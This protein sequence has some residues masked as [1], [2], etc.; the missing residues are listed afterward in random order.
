VQ[1]RERV[2]RAIANELRRQATVGVQLEL[3]TGGITLFGVI[4]IPALAVA[5]MRACDEADVAH[6]SGSERRQIGLG[7]VERA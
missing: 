6:R 7:A 2:E 3:L 1:Q 4:D 5:V